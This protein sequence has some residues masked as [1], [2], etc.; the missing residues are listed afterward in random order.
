MSEGPVLDCNGDPIYVGDYVECLHPAYSSL[1]LG[2]HRRV[3]A[4]IDGSI[5]LR[6]SIYG[7]SVYRPDRFRRATRH[8]KAHW[9]EDQETT[10]MF[11]IA[12]R[13]SPDLDMVEVVMSTSN[14]QNLLAGRTKEEIQERIRTRLSQHPDEKWLIC[15]GNTIGE[16]ADPPVRF[17]SL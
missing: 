3:Q 13:W 17:R 2:A 6:N 16:R 8:N 9:V 11:H 15:S 10:T 7:A 5:K 12:I 1:P 14:N 4:I